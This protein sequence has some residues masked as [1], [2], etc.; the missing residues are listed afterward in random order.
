MVKNDINIKVYT[1]KDRKFDDICSYLEKNICNENLSENGGTLNYS[2]LTYG[3]DLLIVA[4]DKSKPVG[5]NSI[6]LIEDGVYIYQIALKN[7]YKHKGIGTSMM[8]VAI[9]FANNIDQNVFAHVRDYNTASQKMM[10]G[11]GFKKISD[12]KGNY[13]YLLDQKKINKSH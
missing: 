13:L 7:E 5:Y 8:Q 6:V 3:S 11:L 2:N 12:N 1:P 4:F 9:D 10:E